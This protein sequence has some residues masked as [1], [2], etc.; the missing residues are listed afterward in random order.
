LES[1][2]A[3]FGIKPILLVTRLQLGIT[4]IAVER[5]C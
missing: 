3:P 2:L 1:F 5:K 4:A